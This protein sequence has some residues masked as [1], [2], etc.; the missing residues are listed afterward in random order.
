M[1]SRLSRGPTA[2]IVSGFDFVRFAPGKFSLMEF[3]PAFLAVPAPHP[4]MRSGGCAE[5]ELK[6]MKE[7]GIKT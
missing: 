3:S 6:H 5:K 7:F 2:C 1:K 4:P